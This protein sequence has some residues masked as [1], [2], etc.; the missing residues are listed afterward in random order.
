MARHSDRPSITIARR[1]HRPLIVSLASRNRIRLAFLTTH[2]DDRWIPSP[3]TRGLTT[4]QGPRP[5][6][7]RLC[8]HSPLDW[9]DSPSASAIALYRLSTRRRVVDNLSSLCS[10]PSLISLRDSHTC[11]STLLSTELI[12][13][14]RRSLHSI[15]S[16]RVVGQSASAYSTALS[17]QVLFWQVLFAV[18][19]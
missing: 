17:R 11:A 7:S 16:P 14:R 5:R 8:L 4:A 18:D 3:Q 19:C 15:G 1:S 9:I 12:H 6:F 10:A 2:R 13:H